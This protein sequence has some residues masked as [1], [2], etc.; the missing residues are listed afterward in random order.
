MREFARLEVKDD[1]AFEQVVARGGLNFGQVVCRLF[2]KW[3]TVFTGQQ[4]FVI[5][6]ADLAFEGAGV[7]VLGSSLFHVPKASVGILDPQKESVM[8]PAQI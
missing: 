6:R 5:E 1:E 4:A 8:C 2:T 3:L 7:P